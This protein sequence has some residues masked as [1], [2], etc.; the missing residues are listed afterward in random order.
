[1]TKSKSQ[2]FTSLL[3]AKVTPGQVPMKP[4]MLSIAG[5]EPITIG[6]AAK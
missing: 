6:V 4:R 3:P 1:M 2:A 5:F